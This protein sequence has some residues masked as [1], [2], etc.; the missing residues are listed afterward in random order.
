MLIHPETHLD[1]VRERDRDLIAR[2]DRHQ[3]QRVRPSRLR[4][5]LGRNRR[6]GGETMETAPAP[7]FR[8]LAH[9]VNGGVEVTLFWDVREN[10]LAVT[11]SDPRSGE[12][13]VLDTELS[14]A[15]DVFYHPYAH[16]AFQAP[17]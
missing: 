2:S 9:R 16:A 15:L 3:A 10:R 6:V 7:A 1:F 12:S 11:V 14:R 13:F 4:R 8:E 17:A 5:A